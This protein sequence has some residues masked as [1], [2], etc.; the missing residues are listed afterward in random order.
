MSTT[1]KIAI[2]TTPNHKSEPHN[3]SKKMPSA[4]APGDASTQSKILASFMIP[5]QIP[6]LLKKAS[7]IQQKLK[8]P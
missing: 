6:E 4:I 5:D 3:K 8:T 7:T 2:T 1:P